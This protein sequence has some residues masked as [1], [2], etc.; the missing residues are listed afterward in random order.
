MKKIMTFL[1]SFAK[2]FVFFVPIPVIKVYKLSIDYVTHNSYATRNK[3][4][5]CNKVVIF[6]SKNL[7]LPYF[8]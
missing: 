5:M 7:S 6:I 8:L 4:P 1:E 3:I 2:E